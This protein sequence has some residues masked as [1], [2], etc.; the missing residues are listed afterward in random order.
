MQNCL[1]LMDQAATP[2]CKRN[3][4]GSSAEVMRDWRQAG[5]AME[6]G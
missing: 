1:M 4:P 2:V 6:R 3:C 5:M